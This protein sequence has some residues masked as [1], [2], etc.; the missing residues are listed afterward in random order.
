[1]TTQLADHTSE[2][3]T[4]NYNF[5]LKCLGA[6]ATVVVTVGIVATSAASSAQSAAAMVAATATAPFFTLIL[7]VILL[8]GVICLLSYLFENDH[9]T[10]IV[11]APQH[12]AYNNNYNYDNSFFSP[13]FHYCT[14]T[15]SHTDVSRQ[16]H[17]D[18]HTYDAYHHGN[19][20]DTHVHH[21]NLH[22][23]H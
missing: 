18:M 20:G 3:N 23:H 1:M 6:L 19:S 7:G 5:L 17:A 15:H 14:N 13:P 8:I 9:H 4:I 10:L 2:T 12:P 16:P 11:R 22:S 21:N